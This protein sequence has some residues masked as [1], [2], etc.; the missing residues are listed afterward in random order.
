MSRPL[1]PFEG[2]DGGGCRPELEKPRGG[3]YS[4]AGRRARRKSRAS[5]RYSQPLSSIICAR[6]G[7]NRSGV[8]GS[9]DETQGAHLGARFRQVCVRVVADRCVFLGAT[10]N[11]P[12]SLLLGDISSYT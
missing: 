5:G 8:S 10:E 9:L 6:A 11:D 7:E 2:D 4:A 12:Q 3:S 1:Q